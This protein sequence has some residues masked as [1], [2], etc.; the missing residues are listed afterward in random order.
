VEYINTTPVYWLDAYSE[1]G[2]EVVTPWHAA[3]WFAKF[4]VSGVWKIPVELE[5]KVRTILNPLW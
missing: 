1:D 2:P 3:S 4:G 5:C